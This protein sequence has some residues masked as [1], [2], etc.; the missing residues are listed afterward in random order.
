MAASEAEVMSPEQ[1]W[2]L[3]GDEDVEKYRGDPVEIT[4]FDHKRARDF[5]IFAKTVGSEREI[6]NVVVVHDGTAED[7]EDEEFFD[8]VRPSKP[9]PNL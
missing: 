4:A 3:V 8:I 5:A 7:Q 1:I 2:A 9:L 6:D